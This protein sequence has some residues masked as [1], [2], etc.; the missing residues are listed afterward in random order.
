MNLD[1]HRFARLRKALLGIPSRRDVLRGLAGVGLGMGAARL[2]GVVDA[3]KKRKRKNKRKKKAK[4]NE[5]G[6]L[7]VGEP[8]KN[9]DQCCAGICEGKKCRAHDTGTCKQEGP[10]L[11]VID[12]PLALTCNDDATCRCFGTTA[13][14]IVCAR[15]DAEGCADCG[16]DADCRALGYPPE[17][18]CVPMSTGP[19]AGACTGSTACLIPCALELSSGSTD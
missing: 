14:S 8:C 1:K 11:C 3:K 9:A 17:A 10:E 18:V 5:F 12:P 13:D 19:C 4:A 2:P 16:R 15:Y 6:C 7:E